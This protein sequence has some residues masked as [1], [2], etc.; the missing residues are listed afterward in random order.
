MLNKSIRLHN[1]C[2]QCAYFQY[3]IFG[4]DYVLKL[5][6]QF[7]RTFR[8]TAWGYFTRDYIQ[9]AEVCNICCLKMVWAG[10]SGR[11]V[12]GWFCGVLIYGS[13]MIKS[14]WHINPRTRQQFTASY[15]LSPLSYLQQHR[16]TETNIHGLKRSR[17]QNQVMSTSRHWQL[18]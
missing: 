14:Y 7:C 18:P 17:I 9:L 11:G 12:D 16:K 6:N 4:V 2:L 10:V 8:W 3:S 15:Y 5:F 1:I 13:E